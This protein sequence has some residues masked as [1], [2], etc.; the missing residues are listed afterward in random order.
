MFP[1]GIKD[2]DEKI[3]LYI[4]DID[5]ISRRLIKMSDMEPIKVL[6]ICASWD[7]I[8]AKDTIDMLVRDL[9]PNSTRPIEYY[10][11]NPEDYGREPRGWELKKPRGK[12][13]S[14]HN[15]FK[16]KYG[17]PEDLESHGVI[18]EK[19][20]YDIILFS[21][22]L[23]Y[24]PEKIQPNSPLYHINFAF[25]FTESIMKKEGHVVLYPMWDRKR[26]AV[27]ED[28]PIVGLDTTINI[29]FSKVGLIGNNSGSD[30]K[31]AYRVYQKT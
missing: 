17:N 18:F 9:Y 23:I 14:E 6:T 8:E 3:L 28:I 22:C 16:V 2:I 4:D 12:F 1:T 31:S 15:Y 27:K 13:I 26:G 19:G 10:A 5:I 30:K 29:E 24:H 11:A 20:P 25:S 21:Y 7:E